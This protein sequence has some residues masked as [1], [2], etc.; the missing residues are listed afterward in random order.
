MIT[1]FGLQCSL[2]K[3]KHLTKRQRKRKKI[4]I[5]NRLGQ[6]YLQSDT[7]SDIGVDVDVDNENEVAFE[8]DG[9]CEP[10]ELEANLCIGKVS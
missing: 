2:T 9:Y 5:F 4:Q 8:G 6:I 7:E 3:M 1:L 10:G